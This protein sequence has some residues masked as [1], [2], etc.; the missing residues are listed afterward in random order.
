[1]VLSAVGFA[2]LVAVVVVGDT[3]VGSVVDEQLAISIATHAARPALCMGPHLWGAIIAATTLSYGFRV[4][5]NGS[6]SRP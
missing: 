6:P 1:M 5:P 4:P 2:A 3:D